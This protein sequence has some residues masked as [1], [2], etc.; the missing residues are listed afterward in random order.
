[1]ALYLLDSDAIIDYSR[2]ITATVALIENLY[3]AGDQL[4]VCDVVVAEVVAGFGTQLPPELAEL[5][6]A[7]RYLP[8]GQESARQAG[9][10][11]HSYA[12]Q[13][14]SLTTTDVLIA[15]AARGH[16]A[17]LVTGNVRHYPMPE[18]QLLPVP[19]TRA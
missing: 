9:L 1:M 14:V 18:V 16:G 2:G 13:G 10:W 17:I 6:Q 7:C 4:S 19:R 12:R 15:A 3:H 11:R 5:M 8:T